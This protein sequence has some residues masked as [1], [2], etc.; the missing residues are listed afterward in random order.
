MVET[1]TGF[2]TTVSRRQSSSTSP[3]IFCSTNFKQASDTSSV[4]NQNPLRSAA[5]SQHVAVFRSFR[6]N[7]ACL[8][9]LRLEGS[10]LG[11]SRISDSSSSRGQVPAR[12][13]LPDYS[14][15]KAALALHQATAW[16]RRE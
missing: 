9:L 12:P 1:R 15:I 6:T 10:Q 7:Q 11:A 13:N 3:H 4:A 5:A 14:Y 2:L 8:L 16:R